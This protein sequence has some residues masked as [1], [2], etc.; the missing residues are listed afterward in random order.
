MRKNILLAEMY[1]LQ[2]I[3][4][5]GRLDFLKTKY[6]PLII[7]NAQLINDFETQ[8]K[9][10]K[11]PDIGEKLIDY[12]ARFD[13]DKAKK[14]TQWML[15][16]LMKRNIRLE[17]LPR[18]TDNLAKFSKVKDRLPIE[19]RDI[20]RFKT[21]AALG[22]AL[23]PP[24]AKTSG[25]VN[26]EYEQEMYQQAE[27]LLNNNTYRIVVPKTKEASCFFGRNTE[28]CTAAKENNR[29]DNYSKEGPLYIVLDK[30]NNNRWQFFFDGDDPQFMDERDER[31]NIDVFANDHPEIVKF[32]AS[33]GRYFSYALRLKI[34]GYT[35]DLLN[36][37][38]ELIE[39]TVG[40]EGYINDG[41][42]LAF[43][44]S[45][46]IEIF[47]HEYGDDSL[48]W[49]LKVL[50]GK[51]EI[52]KTEVSFD[53]FKTILFN[54]I[55]YKDKESLLAYLMQKHIV[56]LRTSK[57]YY[58]RDPLQLQDIVHD[59]DLDLILENA[60]T[61]GKRAG[62]EIATQLEEYF[63]ASFRRNDVFFEINGEWVKDF[64]WTSPLCVAISV[65]KIIE[66]MARNDDIVQCCPIIERIMNY[67][68]Y[69]TSPP[70]EPMVEYA[71]SGFSC[72]SAQNQFLTDIKNLPNYSKT[73][74][75]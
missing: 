2:T 49:A 37:L 7:A 58:G 62:A 56:A 18:V 9:L 22:D 63:I 70:G 43:T 10:K 20:Q 48:N 75:I 27:V 39:T 65:D 12:V 34:E 73:A 6:A 32:F 74:R 36:D 26:R 68:P 30:K 29:F 15:D 1:G 44:K 54:N 57:V 4:L 45:S 69:M 35:P 28:W 17:D 5:E 21:I 53:S 14:Y 13:P 59:A 19:Q 52:D 31:I 24:V 41:K 25:D 33:I 67:N 66:E 23:A 72:R 42:Y 3:L 38:S 64:S 47:V 55:P 8:T 51:I 71:F 61:E 40:T 16:L 11:S 60:Y 50:Q 46:K